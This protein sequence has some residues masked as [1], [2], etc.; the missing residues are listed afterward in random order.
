MRSTNSP[1]KRS[2]H[3]DAIIV[4]SSTKFK[5]FLKNREIQQIKLLL[6]HVLHLSGQ[7]RSEW[8]QTYG[9]FVNQAFDALV[10]DSNVVLDE[11]PM[12]DDVL[13]LSHE[14]VTS[15]R[16]ALQLMEGILGDQQQLVS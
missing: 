12:E 2:N 14:L 7:E 16:D 5:L 3:E 6:S 15:L 10:D 13:A 9:D 8:I 1:A 11:L 4:E